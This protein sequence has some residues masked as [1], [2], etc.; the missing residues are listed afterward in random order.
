MH[1][2]SAHMLE[3]NPCC[4][5][6]PHLVILG[7]GAS[8][9][10][11]PNGDG[12]GVSVPLMTDLD[13]VAGNVWWSLVREADVPRTTFET[14]YAWLKQAGRFGDRLAEVE[15]E[16]A[17]HFRKMTLP[18]VPT[19]YDHLVL[20]MRAQ[21]TIATFNWDPFLLLTYQRHVQRFGRSRLP[22]IRFLHG[23]VLYATCGQHD[24]LGIA[25]MN[26]THCGQALRSVGPVYPEERKDYV[27]DPLLRRE[28]RVVQRQLRSAFHLTIFGYSGPETD[29]EARQ[30]LRQA[31][32]PDDRTTG[33]L[34][35]L[36]LVGRAELEERWRKFIP[37]SHLLANS[38]WENCSIARWPRRT[39]E[40]KWM[41]SLKGTP[42][43]DLGPCRA[44]S[45]AE[46]QGWYCRISDFEQPLVDGRRDGVALT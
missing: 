27:S 19:I 14:R 20:G 30:M 39:M 42:T 15:A 17:E 6:S 29:V 34:E 3:A 12:R 5:G 40:W 43:E 41:A 21:D 16:L 1:M 13:D 37:F 8:K 22:D 4:N 45:L 26:C 35:V 25:G 23:S 9:A 24:V 44:G 31:W 32:S 46:V 11:F 2:V 7:A 36:D 33:H 28:W 38:K 18:E 10:A